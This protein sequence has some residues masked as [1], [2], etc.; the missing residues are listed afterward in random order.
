M[1]V[2]RC[3]HCGTPQTESSRCWVC[4]RSS[5]SCATCR[6][7]RRAVAGTWGY[8]GVDRNRTPLRGD[9]LRGCWEG[10]AADTFVPDVESLGSGSLG[11]RSL[12]SRSEGNPSL[13]GF[14]TD[15]PS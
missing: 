2:W 3:P 1:P 10:G 12:G 13:G 14:W 5:T 11:S 15:K 9:E 6:N 8:C 7:F 4:K